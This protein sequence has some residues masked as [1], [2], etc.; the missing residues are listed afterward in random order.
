MSSW[1][2]LFKELDSSNQLNIIETILEGEEKTI[3]DLENKFNSLS[4]EEATVVLKETIDSLKESLL[5]VELEREKKLC[6]K[7]GHIYTDWIHERHLGF[8]GEVPYRYDVRV[9]KCN[10]CGN[11]DIDDK[12][13]TLKKGRKDK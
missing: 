2:K 1:G 7:E 6:T 8:K 3:I 5:K 10:R 9:R 12:P 11:I 4:K 13:K